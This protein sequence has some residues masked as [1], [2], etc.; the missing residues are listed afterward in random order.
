MKGRVYNKKES[1]DQSKVQQ[2]F[3]NRFCKENPLASV[4]VRG[5][6]NDGI[7]YKRNE[8]EK[9]LLLKLIDLSAPKTILDIGCGCGRWVE[10]L[11]P[12]IKHYDGIDF[13]E[14]YIIAAQDFY[15]NFENINFY[16]MNIVGLDKFK[17]KKSYDLIILNGICMYLNDS[18]L[19]ELFLKLRSFTDKN[20]HI[21]LRESVSIINERLTLKEFPSIE[22]NV[23]YNAIYRT[24]QEYNDLISIA[25]LKIVEEG[26]LLNESTGKREETDQKYWLLELEKQ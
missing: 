10:N 15:K 9:R 12:F 25:K 16:N 23:E 22:L 20:S 24:P 19:E 5:S 3:E 1:I 17:I 18:D 26:F 7:A 6:S 11:N 8:N 21:Y 14:Q 4:M 13:A 2:F